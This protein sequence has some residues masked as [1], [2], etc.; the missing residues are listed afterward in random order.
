[1]VG[2]WSDWRDTGQ[3][4][5]VGVMEHRCHGQSGRLSY[6]MVWTLHASHD[7]HLRLDRDDILSECRVGAV[8]RQAAISPI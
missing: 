8:P 2:C 5:D 3:P 4:L 7:S 6:G 1:M